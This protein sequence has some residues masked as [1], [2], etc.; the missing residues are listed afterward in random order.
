MQEKKEGGGEGFSM[1]LAISIKTEDRAP[2][3]T[4]YMFAG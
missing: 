4:W 2:P 1:F 3:Y